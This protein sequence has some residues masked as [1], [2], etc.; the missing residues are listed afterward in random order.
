MHVNA[1]KRPRLRL[2]GRSYSVLHRSILER[3]G[4]RCQ[5]CGSRIG[6]EVHHIEPRSQLGPDAEENLLTLCHKCHREVHMSKSARA[7]S[8]S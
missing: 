6:L 7:H 4:W 3:D 8:P 5:T 1:H 2:N